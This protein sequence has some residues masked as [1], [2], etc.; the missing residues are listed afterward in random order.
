MW[1]IVFTDR[2]K[3][4]GTQHL[5]MTIISSSYGSFLCNKSLSAICVRFFTIFIR[6]RSG[7]RIAPFCFFFLAW[8]SMSSDDAGPC[9]VLSSSRSRHGKKSS[10][11]SQVWYERDMKGKSRL[12]ASF[13]ELFSHMFRLDF[14]SIFWTNAPLSCSKVSLCFWI[15]DT[16]WF[17]TTH[18]SFL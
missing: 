11:S 2:Y 14:G 18:H 16:P 5:R 4:A 8:S 1:F 10:A 13:A 15:S 17:F 6:L 7:E 3:L 9:P 12:A